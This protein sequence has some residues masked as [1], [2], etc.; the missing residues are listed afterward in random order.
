LA[1][2]HAGVNL[3]PKPTKRLEDKIS[4]AALTHIN[5]KINAEKTAIEAVMFLVYEVR[6]SKI[7]AFDTKKSRKSEHHMTNDPKE[8]IQIYQENKNR[9]LTPRING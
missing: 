6:A 3:P 9:L 5:K 1:E 4:S 7:A 8:I 2:E